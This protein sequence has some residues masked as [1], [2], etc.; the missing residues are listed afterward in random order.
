MKPENIQLN[1]ALIAKQQLSDGEVRALQVSHVLK[2][3]LFDVARQ[4]G[5]NQPETM[6]MLSNMWEALE[7]EQQRLW[8]FQKDR[9]FHYW[10][11]LPGCKC[12]VMDNRDRYGT[13]YRVVSHDCPAHGGV[14]AVDL[15]EID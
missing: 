1:P 15:P 3:A 14:V 10:F 13:K 9:N 2:D 12:P 5:D 8:K 4:Y 11:N 7:F 6:Q